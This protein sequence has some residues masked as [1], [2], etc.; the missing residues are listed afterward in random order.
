MLET[1]FRYLVTINGKLPIYEVICMPTFRNGS[2]FYLG[3]LLA[4]K[5]NAYESTKMKYQIG[6]L[7]NNHI[8]KLIWLST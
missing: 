8:W 2:Q 6:S 4:S 7:C 5:L 1:L 3:K